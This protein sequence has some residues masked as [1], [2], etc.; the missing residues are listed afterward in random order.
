MISFFHEDQEQDKEKGTGES[1]GK[2]NALWSPDQHPGF[3]SSG[4]KPGR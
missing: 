4:S 1:G 2:E 3:L